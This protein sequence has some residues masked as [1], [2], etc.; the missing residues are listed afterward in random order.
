MDPRDWLTALARVFSC[1]DSMI[2]AAWL[3]GTHKVIHMWL[4]DVWIGSAFRIS[5]LIVFVQKYRSFV[6]RGCANTIDRKN[7]PKY[8]FNEVFTIVLISNVCT[9]TNCKHYCLA[10]TAR[11][12]THNKKIIPGEITRSRSGLWCGFSDFIAEYCRLGFSLCLCSS[13]MCMFFKER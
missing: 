5:H 2:Y 10:N 8:E 9:H 7:I 13:W 1:V 4:L 6:N 3:N 12:Q 11:I